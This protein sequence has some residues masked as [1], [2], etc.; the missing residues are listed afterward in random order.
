MMLAEDAAKHLVKGGYFISSGILVEKE[1]QVVEDLRKKGDV[2]KRQARVIGVNSFGASCLMCGLFAVGN[3]CYWQ[4]MPSMIYDVCEAEELASGEK[5]SGAVISLQ[6][7]SESL[8]AAAGVQILG[9]ILEQA[10]FNEAVTAQTTTA[11]NWVSSSFSLIPGIG[12]LIVAL[13]ISRYPINKH[14]FPRILAGVERRR[15]GEAVDLEEYK[16]IF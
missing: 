4:L 8:S 1:L 15:R 3:T 7:L 6:A 13:V 9:I 12:M 16:D 5:H 2:Y 14:T 10:G 11:L